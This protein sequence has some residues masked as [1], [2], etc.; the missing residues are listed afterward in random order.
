[1]ECSWAPLSFSLLIIAKSLY[2][3]LCLLDALIDL[4]AMDEKKCSMTFYCWK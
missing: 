3:C 1:M 2:S 4:K